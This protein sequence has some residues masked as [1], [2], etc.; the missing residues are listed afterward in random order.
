MCVV[1]CVCVCVCYSYVCACV[2]V[3]DIVHN[4]FNNMHDKAVVD[5]L[6][7]LSSKLVNINFNHWPAK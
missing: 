1:L 5:K 7:N 6:K 3:Y 2:C 4:I